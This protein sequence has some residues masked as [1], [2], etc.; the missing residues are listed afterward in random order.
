[1]K[2]RVGIIGSG[3]VVEQHL[4]ALANIESA[5]VVAVAGRN[6]AR[7]AR[8][9]QG[10]HATGYELQQL[11]EMLRAERLDAILI[12]TPPH[13]RGDLEQLCSQHC[14]A[15]FVEKPVATE[16]DTARRVADA[17]DQQDTLV[18]VGFMNRYRQTVGRAKQELQTSDP[19]VLVNGTWVESMPSPS[20]WRSR[21][22]SGGQFIE[23]C[24]HLVDLSR[25]LVGEIE[26]VSA[27]AA[28]GFIRDVPDYSVDDASVV[29]VRFASGAIGT[30]STGCFVRDGHSSPLGIGLTIATRE[31]QLAFRQ[32]EC[33]LHV[34]RTAAQQHEQRSDE[35][36][37]F[38]VELRAWLRA[39]ETGDRSLILSDYHDAIE[40]LKV[41]LAAE[42]SAQL[43]RA[44]LISEL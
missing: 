8:V 17:L 3:W 36:S 15:L 44:V 5:Q 25:Y 29:N 4:K 23:Q 37:I 28:R 31:V 10:A 32:W 20:W 41:G 12:C 27:F 18:S 33:H 9:S 26:Q 21:P 11:P 19:P 42:R 2:L 35:P 43:G 24:T 39:L 6:T 34:Q 38:E 7:V 30:F 40:T 16:L 14:K 22:Q 1:M 13:A